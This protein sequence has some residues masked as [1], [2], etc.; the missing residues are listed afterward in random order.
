MPIMHI[1]INNW[2]E[3]T[4]ISIKSQF[5]FTYYYNWKSYNLKSNANTQYHG[6]NFYHLCCDHAFV[7]HAFVYVCYAFFSSLDDSSTF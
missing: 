1:K 4:R 5:D 2:M 6:F 3:T 7:F